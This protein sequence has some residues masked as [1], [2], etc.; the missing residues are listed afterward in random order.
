VVIIGLYNGIL[1]EWLASWEVVLSERR[2]AA[3]PEVPDAAL[4]VFS[5]RKKLSQLD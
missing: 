3:I 4:G 1:T 5:T 2:F